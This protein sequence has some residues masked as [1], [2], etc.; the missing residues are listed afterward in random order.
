MTQWVVDNYPRNFTNEQ[1]GQ[2]HMYFEYLDGRVTDADGNILKGTFGTVQ[3]DCTTGGYDC[4]IAYLTAITYDTVQ[5]L[6]G[7]FATDYY[8]YT[9]GNT[10]VFRYDWKLIC[11]S[12]G[13]A[14]LE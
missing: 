6:V 12:G 9:N 1:F 7:P 5:M 3:I 10:S 4:L 8:I 14:C 2:T 13:E 11:E